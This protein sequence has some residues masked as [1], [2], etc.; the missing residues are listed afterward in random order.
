MITQERLKELLDYDPKTGVFV[1]KV[2]IRG[3][4]KTGDRAGSL[5]K[6][7]GYIQINV[8][9]KKY[10]AHRLAWLYVY[11][12]W[13]KDTI[14][15]INRQRADNR[16]ENLREATVQQQNFNVGAKGCHLHKPSKKW[17]AQIMSNGKRK[18]LGYFD[19][20]TEAMAAYFTAK[21]QLHNT[22]EL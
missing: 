19:T 22:E 7:L 13:P 11:G 17:M 18:Y 5:N 1:R 10:F 3:G 21:K 20:E 12:C 6:H 14:D 2:D 16:I 4:A 9:G 15:H 8:D